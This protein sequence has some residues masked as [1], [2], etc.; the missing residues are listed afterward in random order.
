[1]QAKVTEKLPH[2]KLQW[3][4]CHQPCLENRHSWHKQPG[5][6][7]TYTSEVFCTDKDSKRLL[8][9]SNWRT[10]QARWT[11]W[12]LTKRPGEQNEIPCSI[13]SDSNFDFEKLTEQRIK[14]LLLSCLQLKIGAT[15]WPSLFFQK[16][17]G[18]LQS[19]YIKYLWKYVKIGKLRNNYPSKKEQTDLLS[20]CSGLG[21]FF[22]F[23][24]NK[25]LER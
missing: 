12:S 7:I 2:S 25:T 8:P 24:F 10:C 15:I 21:S 16:V 4:C 14:V 23:F 1:M 18:K 6:H 5:L 19:L 3:D 9:L 17:M 20:S 11:V 13:S 22:F